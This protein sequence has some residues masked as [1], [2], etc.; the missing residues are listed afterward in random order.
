MNKRALYKG[1]LEP[2][3]LKLLQ[4]HKRMYGYELTMMVKE[5]TKGEFVITEGALYPLLHRLEEEGI[6]QA[7][8][9][10]IGNRPRKYYKLTSK[11]H[12]AQQ[13]AFQELSNFI[14]TLQLLSKPAQI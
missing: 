9:E 14:E 12:T 10:Y 8:L 11:G 6:L 3:I 7:E 4:E 2:I 13:K 5:Q 1:C